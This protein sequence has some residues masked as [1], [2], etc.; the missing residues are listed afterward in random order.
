M[1]ITTSR[2]L[3]EAVKWGSFLFAGITAIVKYFKG[4]KLNYETIIRCLFK[5][6]G[7]TQLT[8]VIENKNLLKYDS[9]TI[10][11]F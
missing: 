8:D 2:T 9:Y 10:I 5:R 4:F 6:L 1:P 7:S 3:S 11:T